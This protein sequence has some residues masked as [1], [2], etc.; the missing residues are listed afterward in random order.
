LARD[1]VGSLDVVEIDAA[2]HNGVDDARELRERAAFAPVRDRY[3]IFILDEAHMA[4]TQGFNALLKIVEEPPEHVKFIFATT[5]P[6]KVIGTIRS[7]THHYPFRLV[8]PAQLLEYLEQLVKSEKVS[9]A[10]GVLAL[11]VRAGGGSVRDSLSLLD[12]LIAG[13]EGG[14]VEYDLA[15]ALLGFTHEALL[16]EIVDA[17]ATHDSGAVFGAIDRVIESGQDPRRFV[18]DLLERLRDLIVISAVGDWAQSVM[19]GTAPDVLVKLQN[20]ALRFGGAAL[21][22]AAAAISEGLTDMAG[23]TSPKLMLELMCGRVLVPASDSTEVG[24][25]ARIERLERRIGLAGAESAAPAAAPA[26]AA[27]T[28]AVPAAK[29]AP[30][31][32]VAAAAQTTPAATQVIPAV[33]VSASQLRSSWPAILETVKA[34][35]RNA[36]MIANTLE[37]VDFADDVLTLLFRSQKD[38]ETFKSAGQAPDVVRNA[39]RDTLGVV[40]KFKPQI[41]EVAPPPPTEAITVPDEEVA[42]APAVEVPEVEVPDVAVVPEPAEPA[43]E[44]APKKPAAKKAPAKKAEPVDTRF[45]ESMLKEVMGAEPIKTPKAAK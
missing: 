42:E 22:H 4:T 15:A 1:G 8:P 45:G 27:S 38:L 3:K 31:Q 6:E 34:T 40:V 24:S 26:P 13:A 14:K 20:Q 10:P 28:P 37:V 41:A 29:A 17:F 23:A 18:E 44:V 35:S 36:W 16:D 21:T 7:R 11:V 9:V 19:R 2:S 25:L 30:A 43:A 33:A 39:I 12:Q 5:E 32:P